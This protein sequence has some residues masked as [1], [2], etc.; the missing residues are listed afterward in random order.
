[1]PL[2]VIAP[3]SPPPALP[4]TKLSFAVGASIAV[5]GGFWL[6]LINR[7]RIVWETNPQYSYG[8]FVPFLAAYLFWVRWPS[9]PPPRPVSHPS[10][11]L[12]L[13]GLLAFC[14]WL[15]RL[16]HEANPQWTAVSWSMA[17][18]VVGL[19]L[20]AIAY[21]AGWPSLRHFAFPICFFFVAVAWPL[22]WELPLTQTLMQMLAKL[23][24]EILGWFGVA[25]NSHGNLIELDVGLVGVDEACSGVR[26]LQS[27]LMASLFVGELQRFSLAGRLALVAAGLALAIFFNV[28]RAVILVVIALHSGLAAVLSWHDPAGYSI[29]AISLAAL[30]L[31]VRLFSKSPAVPEASP[32]VSPWRPL[33][34]YLFLSLGF[35]LLF[36]EASTEAW[37]RLHETSTSRPFAWKV[38]WPEKLPNFAFRPISR[39][40]AAQLAYSEGR[41]GSWRQ[42]DGSRWLMFAFRWN[43]GRTSTMAARVHR[44]ETCLPGGGQ[45]LVA[46]LAPSVIHVGDVPVPFRFYHFDDRGQPLFVFFCLWENGNRD[47]AASGLPQE[48]GRSNFLARVR[49]GQ[50]NLGQQSAE[51]IISGIG[52]ADAAREAFQ[53]QASLLLGSGL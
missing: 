22:Q 21:A 16:V 52:S 7:L 38:L 44:P 33:P 18:E 43:P 34:R 1:M 53:R 19:S 6:S 46:E 30:L 12:A 10:L 41:E 8:W 13:T 51:V 37:Y 25:A 14:F 47:L 2:D 50:R 20:L 42:E 49:I 3:E 15:G 48:Y 29:F 35:W 32:P 36:T 45:K 4:P 31:L 5:L 24:V 28:L 23:A 11:L 27:M 40:V 17:V 9:R 26:S 39:R